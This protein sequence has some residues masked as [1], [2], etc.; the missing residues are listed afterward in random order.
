[1]MPLFQI[2]HKR[3]LKC[4]SSGEM[5]NSP[6][7]AIFPCFLFE[8]LSRTS[9]RTFEAGNFRKNKYIQPQLKFIP[10]DDNYIEPINFFIYY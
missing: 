7:Q 8:F 9:I 6:C 2:Y 10:G 4:Y 1:M 3:I 5:D